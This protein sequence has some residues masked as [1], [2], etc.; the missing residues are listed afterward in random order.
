E[1]SEL[2]DRIRSNKKNL[3]KIRSEISILEKELSELTPTVKDMESK[4]ESLHSRMMEK[5]GEDLKKFDALKKEHASLESEYQ[6]LDRDHAS[7]KSK[8]DVLNK[9]Y[10]VVL[11]KIQETK[12]Q[13]KVTESII[14]E[15]ENAVKE[16]RKNLTEIEEEVRSKKGELGELRKKRS[17]SKE[18]I[19]S[20]RIEKE[21]LEKIIADLNTN[22]RLSKQKNQENEKR[23]KELSE[24]A[25]KYTETE[26]VDDIKTLEF[27]IKRMEIEKEG[28]EPINMRA[29]EECESTEERYLMLKTKDEKILREKKAVLEFIDK[30]ETRK[31][32]VFMAT[33]NGISENFSDIFLE[34]SGGEGDIFLENVEEPFEAGV[35]IETK[36]HG[37]ELKR[38]AAMS[39][40]EKALT[41]LAFIFAIQRYKPAPFY[42]FD[43]IDAH[44][45]DDNVKKV[46]EMI[47]KASEDSQFII[48]T[49]R[50]IMMSSADRLFG[51]SMLNEISEIVA[52]ELQDTQRY[53]G[54]KFEIVEEA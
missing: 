3:E 34:L 7:K 25:E 17:N 19:H 27:K 14:E 39:G 8:V 37:K 16:V 30:V 18:E 42:L 46:A 47:K 1:I 15:H 35:D 24:N 53:K 10:S 44:L 13:S 38:T 12:K 36:P 28:L 2:K 11:E 20:S 51:V 22:I 9:N 50:D 52:V 45:D 41:A 26:I 4:K 48:I 33:F 31:R 23:I 32:A 5:S 29:V 40:G 6:R 43:E 21:K 49:L 54:K